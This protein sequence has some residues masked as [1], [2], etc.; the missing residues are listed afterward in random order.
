MNNLV[1]GSTEAKPEPVAT[2]STTSPAPTI[3][4]KESP[5]PLPAT[6]KSQGL[7]GLLT[8]RIA[9]IFGAS[10]TQSQ[11]QSQTQPAAPVP[12]ALPATTSP[13]VPPKPLETQTPIAK[14]EPKAKTIEPIVQQP[15]MPPSSQVPPVKP[16]P[17]ISRSVPTAAVQAPTTVKPHQQQP[18][19]QAAPVVKQSKS[20]GVQTIEPEPEPTPL[21]PPFMPVVVPAPAAPTQAEDK[22]PKQN[23]YE[24]SLAVQALLDGT[25]KQLQNALDFYENARKEFD[26]QKNAA[27]KMQTEMEGLQTKVEAK[28]G[29]VKSLESQVELFETEHKALVAKSSSYAKTALAQQAEL[30]SREE[31]IKKLRADFLE[32]QRQGEQLEI[33]LKSRTGSEESYQAALAAA[34]DRLEKLTAEVQQFTSFRNALLSQAPPPASSHASQP[35]SSGRHHE[36]TQPSS[37]R[38]G[39]SHAALVQATEESKCMQ[40]L[41]KNSTSVA[42]E[43]RNIT[44]NP[45]ES[46]RSS[47]KIAVGQG[48]PKVRD[49]SLPSSSA[50]MDASQVS[51]ITFN[52]LKR[53]S[54]RDM[55]R[56][57][58]LFRLLRDPNLR[59]LWLSPNPEAQED[60]EKLSK[61]MKAK[62]MSW[63]AHVVNVE[64]LVENHFLLC[65][66]NSP[67]GPV[68]LEK[69]PN[70]VPS[71]LEYYRSF[72]RWLLT[73]QTAEEARS[74]MTQVENYCRTINPI[75]WE[76]L[77]VGFFH[78]LHTAKRERSKQLQ[79]RDKALPVDWHNQTWYCIQLKDLNLRDS[80]DI[81]STFFDHITKLKI[82]NLLVLCSAEDELES[83]EIDVN[84]KLLRL[85]LREAQKRGI[86]VV[87]ES[88]YHVLSIDHIWSRRALSGNEEFS[89][90]FIR[91]DEW[92]RLDHLC[93][94]SYAV[95]EDS[96]G[97]E[98]YRKRI[99][100]ETRGGN[101]HL[102]PTLIDGKM[103]QFYSAY[104]NRYM[105]LELCNPDTVLRILSSAASEMNTSGVLGK[106]FCDV[107]LWIDR[108]GLQEFS[109]SE[110]GTAFF[111][112]IR[113]MMK[114][115]SDKAIVVSKFR[116]SEQYLALLDSYSMKRA[117]NTELIRATGSAPKPTLAISKR[118]QDSPDKARDLDASSHI[119]EFSMPCFDYMISNASHNAWVQTCLTESAEFLVSQIV[120]SSQQPATSCKQLMLI[121]SPFL[122]KDLI[123]K[124]SQI[125]TASSAVRRY[126]EFVYAR[127]GDLLENADP[128]K[129][130]VLFILQRLMPQPLALF[131]GL[132]F[133]MPSD[134]KPRVSETSNVLFADGYCSLLMDESKRMDDEESMIPLFDWSALMDADQPSQESETSKSPTSSFQGDHVPG[135]A[136]RSL[137]DL[138]AL[139]TKNKQ[140]FAVSML[141]SDG[142]SAFVVGNLGD[143]QIE[144]DLDIADTLVRLH[145]PAN[146][147]CIRRILSSSD[148]TVELKVSEQGIMVR[149]GPFDY[150]AFRLESTLSQLSTVEPEA[151]YKVV[152]EASSF[153]PKIRLSDASMCMPTARPVV[154][155]W[156]Q[157]SKSGFSVVYG[158]F[159]KW[160]H[161]ILL[162]PAVD[163]SGQGANK[164]GPYANLL[165]LPSGMHECKFIV[166]GVWTCSKEMQLKH[167]NLPPTDGM[168]NNMLFVDAL[169]SKDV[170]YNQDQQ[171]ASTWHNRVMEEIRYFKSV[172]KSEVTSK[173]LL[174]PHLFTWVANSPGLSALP[175]AAVGSSDEGIVSPPRRVLLSGS[176]D[177]WKELYPLAYSSTG[178]YY[179]VVLH[180]PLGVY[181]YR[182][183]VDGVWCISLRDQ[184]ETDQTGFCSNVL[185]L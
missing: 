49:V 107:D 106:L 129:L 60:I 45:R 75:E 139:E 164:A 182:F 123:G 24:S 38:A 115:I 91:R 104:G 80:V 174:V 121:D 102:I 155:E 19:G 120:K 7:P 29:R 122:D 14:E 26:E 54:W 72:C 16:V 89:T 169:D 41:K 134:L 119:G 83:H 152:S 99:I 1:S 110:E 167:T 153:I 4:S 21:L 51:R 136:V 151:L 44:L 150:C 92:K 55:R 18:V 69:E 6:S 184:N 166:D 33:K 3:V 42:G 40:W 35:R 117:N 175:R 85:L 63:K 138:F 79:E 48:S 36:T 165:Y 158:S 13:V 28:E 31:Q 101:H 112:L 142:S 148:D 47:P 113:S 76:V 30:V 78:I 162:P 108:T 160:K 125:A 183:L 156:K 146:L 161:G 132:E 144:F 82:K 130:K 53:L 11:N 103:V 109:I 77:Y 94:D 57:N 181:Y 176:F 173:N 2:T 105:Q 124:A 68:D 43:N 111:A 154:V 145:L 23:V 25:R 159:T 114:L 9:A 133:V 170:L 52:D 61:A 46:S 17:E 163:V 65:I 56:K 22:T 39:F 118:A 58:E 127:I 135:A 171:L 143:S 67:V 98:S 140:S 149:L 87:S 62:A 86:R 179:W 12:A 64:A 5:A 8:G 90:L 141:F 70:Q 177:G 15:T 185:Q 50:A 126:D 10:P 93:T 81:L 100:P 71:W 116:D 147:F 178:K 84:A 172:H 168:N 59:S 27:K 180:L 97:V 128:R 66:R 96:D 20:I 74:V 37:S 157:S 34:E 88:R 131:E 32:L 95:Y 137:K 73:N